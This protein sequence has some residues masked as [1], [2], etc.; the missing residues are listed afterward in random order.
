MLWQRSHADIDATNLTVFDV[1][2][3]A[4]TVHMLVRRVG[5]AMATHICFKDIGVTEAYV[6]VLMWVQRFFLPSHKSPGEGKMDLEDLL[7]ST[8][9]MVLTG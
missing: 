2:A 9:H 3:D 5:K 7:H 6:S 1:C 8:V 4:H